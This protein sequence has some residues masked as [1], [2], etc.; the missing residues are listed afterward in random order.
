[1]AA[2]HPTRCR[3]GRASPLS[4]H[5]ITIKTSPAFTARPALTPT[6][7][8]LPP[9]P[10]LNSLSPLPPPDPLN[11]F[12]IFS[13][14]TPSGG[15]PACPVPPG[16]TATRLI[17]PG[18]GAVSVRLRV[19]PVAPP[20]VRMVWRVSSSTTI[21]YDSPPTSTTHTPS[22][23]RTPAAY[24]TPSISSE[25]TP[26]AV[27][28]ASTSHTSSPTLTRQRSPS[29]WI[30]TTRVSSLIVATY[31]IGARSGCVRSR[32]SPASDSGD[33]PRRERCGFW[34]DRDISGPLVFG[35]HRGDH[36]NRREP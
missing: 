20:R 31:F 29:V 12:S 16:C 35:Q 10:A 27:M 11:S 33:A 19:P 36:R 2:P 5:P 15:S 21:S 13:A 25:Y 18:S 24:D 28:R 6:P 23:S 14:S 7:A 17:L 26:G 8:P 34:R 4:P 1:M 9:P 32:A 22:R 30:S 3:S